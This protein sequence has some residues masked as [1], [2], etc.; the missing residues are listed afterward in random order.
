LATRTVVRY[1]EGGMLD[2]HAARWRAIADQGGS[3]DI[4]GL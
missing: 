2:Q 3:I 1:D 4:L